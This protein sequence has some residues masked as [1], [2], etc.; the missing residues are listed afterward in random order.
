MPPG[1]EDANWRGTPPL[2]SR[3]MRVAS[4]RIFII[5]DAGGYVEPF[6]GEGMTFALEA[7]VA[8]VPLAKR[9]VESWKPS[10][11]IQWESLH[12]QIV[13][14]RQFT[15]RQLAWVLRRPWASIVA[16]NVCRLVP[17]IANRTI[18]KINLP[19]SAFS[20]ERIGST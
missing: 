12:E 3:P 18:A 1:L 9:T 7:A 11:I 15:C 2:T 6:T 13:Q 16:I 14:Q 19:S 17:W 4:E 8:V 20:S 10:I 5:G